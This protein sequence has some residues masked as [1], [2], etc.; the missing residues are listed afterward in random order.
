MEHTKATSVGDR[1]YD[2]VIYTILSVV[3]LGTLYPLLYIVSASISDPLAIA[4][5]E[6]WLW[7]KEITFSAYERVLQNPDILT[8]YRNSIIYLVVGTSIN[9][10]MTTMGAYALSRQDFR[11][12][13]VLTLIF[14]FTLLFNGGLIPTYLVYKNMLGLYNNL[15]VMVIPAAV[16][17]WNL[18]IM[19]TYFQ[20][21]IPYEL[22]EAAFMD[23]CSNVRTLVTIILPLS[24]PILAVMAMYYGVAHWNSYFT[25]L[26]YLND[27]WR[28]PLQ[29]VIRSLLIQEDMGAMAGGSGESIV[30]Q[31]L[32]VESMRYA[33]IVVSSLPMLLVYPLV[34]KHFVKGVMIGAVKG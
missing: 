7:P 26:I 2:A 9:L 5:G 8:G 15:W 25:A 16:S 27:S 33:I 28:Q 3:M 31:L 19:R 14:T 32:L 22:Q 29:M 11:G 30:E 1:I 34:Q 17:V 6:L 20:T 24:K 13:Y 23:G 4:R 21:S 12:R 10:I 18:I